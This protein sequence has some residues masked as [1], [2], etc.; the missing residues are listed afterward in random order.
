MTPEQLLVVGISIMVM[1]FIL[2]ILFVWWITKHKTFI[3]VS[4]Q[5]EGVYMSG[6]GRYRV[7]ND[8]LYPANAF[9]AGNNF[10][11]YDI[12][13]ENK[14]FVRKPFV[15]GPITIGKQQV[16]KRTIQEKQPVLYSQ[17]KDYAIVTESLP[18]IGVEE[19]IKLK[20]DGS[21]LIPWLPQTDL[22]DVG[23]T[24]NTRMVKINDL[25]FQLYEATKNPLTTSE[26][27][28]QIAIPFA[29]IMLAAV[30]VIFFPKMYAAITKGSQAAFEASKDAVWNFLRQNP[31]LE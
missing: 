2:M 24:T 6:G 9:T 10:L 29:L 23:L 30:M 17:I 11:Y 3:Q 13:T 25:R 8:K 21:K 16:I 15:L 14:E 28:I 5:V 12:F 31:P 4:E 7:V 22:R 27:L 20:R 26:V 19:T 1:P 18:I